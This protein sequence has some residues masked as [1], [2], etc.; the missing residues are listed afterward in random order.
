MTLALDDSH[1]LYF[2]SRAGIA[3]ATDADAV[4]QGILTRLRLFRGEWYLD[5]NAGVPWFES[6]FLAGSNIRSIERTIKRQILDTP[7]VDEILSFTASF[8]GSTRSLSISFEVE[9]IFGPSGVLEVS[10]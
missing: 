6:A 7:G 1:D 9:S 5:T 3:I 2:G 4:R 8:D 10:M